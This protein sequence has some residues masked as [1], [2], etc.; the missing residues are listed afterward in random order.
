M[1]ITFEQFEADAHER[2]FDEVVERRW[3]PHQVIDEHRHPFDADALVVQGEMW[4]TDAAGTQHLLPGDRF[5]L[6]AD[7]PHSERYGGDG[8]TYWVARRARAS[9]PLV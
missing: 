8:A 9:A 2:G 4:L 7:V 5:R 3:T 6:E 1:T